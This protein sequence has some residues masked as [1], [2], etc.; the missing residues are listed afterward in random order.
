MPY[1]VFDKYNLQAQIRIEICYV[2][3]FLQIQIYDGNF[4]IANTKTKIFGCHLWDEYECKFFSFTKKLQIWIQTQLFRLTFENTN[5]N[6]YIIT[7][8][9]KEQVAMVMDLKLSIN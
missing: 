2:Y 1:P 3:F 4:F 9:L 7:H 6:T 8:K 5:T